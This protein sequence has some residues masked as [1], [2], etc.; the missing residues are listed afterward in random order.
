MKL[1]TK[2]INFINKNYTAVF[3]TCD[4]RNKPN[5]IFV[6]ICKIEDEDKIIITDNEMKITRKNLQENCNVCLLFNDNKYNV[7]KIFGK[8]KY[9]KSGKYFEYVKKLKDNIGH[10][11][12][13]A[14]VVKV[15]K[16]IEIS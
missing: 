9:F 6:E 11:P 8:A 7:I 13:A 4:S 5:S 16:I 10:N 3:T 12:K 15:L 2:Q 1:S 14:V